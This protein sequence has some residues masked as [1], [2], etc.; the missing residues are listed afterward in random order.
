MAGDRAQLGAAERAIAS[1][2]DAQAHEPAMALDAARLLTFAGYANALADLVGR[3]RCAADRDE[4]SC[5]NVE[6]KVLKMF[7]EIHAKV[8]EHQL[9]AE[10]TRK[11]QELLDQIGRRESG[12][13]TSFDDGFDPPSAPDKGAH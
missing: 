12:A 8:L 11:L 13:T 4:I 9:D 10:G 6:V 1:L 7:A 3:S 5:M 2:A